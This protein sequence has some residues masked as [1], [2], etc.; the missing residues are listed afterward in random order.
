MEIE[1]V[2]APFDANH[3]FRIGQVLGK[4]LKMR[5]PAEPVID[6]YGN[7]TNT[8]RITDEDGDYFIGVFPETP[9]EF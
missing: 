1:R 5:V 7:Y 2:G 4:L 3:A 6:D 8:I 9:R